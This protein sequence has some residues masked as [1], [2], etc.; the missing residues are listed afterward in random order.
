M[1]F[2]IPSHSTEPCQT[3]Q[4]SARWRALTSW[5]DLLENHPA[6]TTSCNGLMRTHDGTEPSLAHSDLCVCV[7]LTGVCTSSHIVSYWVGGVA[8]FPISLYIFKIL[9]YL[10]VLGPVSACR[11]LLC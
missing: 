10:A 8:S 11:I 1:D 4:A 6:E 2:L 3:Y 7:L 9:I 5:N